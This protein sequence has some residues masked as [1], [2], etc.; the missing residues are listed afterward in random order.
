[1]TRPIG[2]LLLA[3]CV[4]T[5][6][7]NA[8]NPATAAGKLPVKRVVLFKNGVGYFEHVGPVHGNE[9]VN[10]A[11]TSGQLNDVLKSLTVLDLN[12]GRIA[13][14]AYGTAAP[15]DR[16][17]GDLRLPIGE[18]A[19]LADFLSALRGT[20]L[21]VR[22]GTTVM[23]GRLLSVERKTRISGGT[24]LEV[25]Y[26]SLI[27]DSGELRTTE[28]SPTFSVR[29]LEA[30][31]TGRVDRYLDLLSA[32]READVRRM[33]ISTEGTGDRSL[34]V[35]YISEVPVWK[36]TYRIV[37]S[38]KA[39]QKPLLQGWA[40]I[41]NVVGEDWNNVELSLVAGAP[42]SFIQNL[43]QPYYTQRPVVGMPENVS[44]T[45]QTHESTLIPGAAQLT[46]MVTD[47]SGA[48]IRGATVKVF[49]A[50]NALVAQATTNDAG[51]YE[52]PL[53]PDGVIRLEAESPGFVR[54]S[55]GGLMASAGTP[56]QQNMQLKIPDTASTV[57]VQTTADNLQSTGDSASTAASRNAGSGRALGSGAGLGLARR[58]TGSGFGSGSGGGMG[59][60]VYRV[61]AAR[62]AA[63]ATARSQALGDLF[64]Y[65]LT[66]PITILKNRSALVPIAQAPITVDKV[67]LWSDQA[68][69]LR[70]QRALWIT[71]STGLTLD[72]GSVSVLEEDTFAGEG[73]FDPIRPGERRL[74]SYAMDLA[75]NASSRIGTEQERVSRVRINHGMMVH[76]SEI[77]EKK[78]Y[79]FR[80]EDSTPRTIIVEHPVRAGYVLR[81]EARPTETTASAMRFS[82]HVDPKQTASLTVEEARPTQT[83]FALTN[84]SNEQVAVFV[85]QRSIDPSIE[86]ALREILAQKNAIA[87]LEGQKSN[88]DDATQKIF[89]DQQRLRE[90]IKALKGTPEEKALLQRYTQQLNEQESR[91]AALQKETEQLDSQIEAAKAH[92]DETI[93][94]LSFDVLL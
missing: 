90:N 19:S 57:E 11:F 42:Q 85:N 65:K 5:S 73:V 8:Q 89:D 44:I 20:K 87:E 59:G 48:A 6:L 94:R 28:I 36:S 63:E 68:G 55:V 52:I 51:S 9:S 7:M 34:Y 27:S 30:G 49:D 81:G 14:V 29:L 43:S 37:L 47:P 26:L 88:R 24:T 38:S 77:R 18:K 72:G 31:L 50:N 54:A 64:E 61:D 39:G 32:G 78:I 91:L 62:A 13:G 25:D 58:G 35:S 46:G 3:G 10:I 21:E 74:F 76:E 86:A 70:P 60:G 4:L 45:P 82:L 33:V 1:M 67:S 56:I 80:N 66:S 71:N 75:V 40:I 15:I 12:G 84:I 83:N 22:S 69:L 41:D 93:Q 16:Q 79:T 23:T 2:I 53:L 17:L 92:L